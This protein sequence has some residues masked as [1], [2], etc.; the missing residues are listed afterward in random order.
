[1]G[2]VCASCDTA[3]SEISQIY[4]K[5]N[6]GPITCGINL[7]NKN[8]ISV[9]SIG[10]GLDRASV[11][12][13][14]IHLYS[15]RPAGTVDES[16]VEEVVAAASDRNLPFVTYRD[17]A[18]GTAT[19]GLAY[20]FDDHDIVGWHGL[21]PMFRYY[22][23]RVTFFI[24]S[25]DAFISPDPEMLRMLREI[26][27]AGHAIEYHSTNHLSASSTAAELGAAAWVEMDI[28]PGLASMRAAGFD[29]RVFAYPFGARSA[30]TDAAVLEVFPL[31]RASDFN[32][33]R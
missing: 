30:E 3:L 33:P 31:V 4:S 9:D 10:A 13:Q 22:D 19:Y 16:T 27:A 28:L 20:S 15:H 21:L 32:C 6:D 29:P 17:L 18:D 24:S 7:D 25:F 26:A 5:P 8:A 1:V 23:A 12:H 11:D 14:I 2:V